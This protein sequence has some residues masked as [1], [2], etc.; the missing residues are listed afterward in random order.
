MSL[1]MAPNVAKI[2][3]VRLPKFCINFLHLIVDS[4]LINESRHCFVVESSS[5]L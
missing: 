4:Y 3:G 2:R 5:H 1:F